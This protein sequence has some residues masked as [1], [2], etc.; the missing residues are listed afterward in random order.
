MAKGHRSVAAAA[1]WH[2]KLLHEME[3]PWL[4]QEEEEESR[5]EGKR[6][7][8]CYSPGRSSRRPNR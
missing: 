1:P 5:T 8:R 4:E 7:R 3:Q 6:R 2:G